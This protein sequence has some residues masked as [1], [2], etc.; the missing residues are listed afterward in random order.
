MWLVNNRFISPNSGGCKSEIGGQRGWGLVRA[1]FQA[2][3]GRLLEEV[4]QRGEGAPW[5][6]L[7]EGESHSWGSALAASYLA[8]APPPDTITLGG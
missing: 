5:G 1:L 4:W 8:K 2:A 7:H 3:D 6:L